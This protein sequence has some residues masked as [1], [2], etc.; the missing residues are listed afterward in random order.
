MALHVAGADGRAGCEVAREDAEL[1]DRRA[2]AAIEYLREAG[3]P[4]AGLVGEYG[5]FVVRA[6]SDIENG[7]GFGRALKTEPA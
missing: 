2:Q 6:D 3:V 4:I 7:G 5:A 1:A